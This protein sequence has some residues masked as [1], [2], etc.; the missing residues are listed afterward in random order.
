MALTT[1]IGFLFSVALWVN[2]GEVPEKHR[3]QQR[4]L[5]MTFAKPTRRSFLSGAAALGAGTAVG[6]FPYIVRAA[7]RELFVGGFASPG[8]HEVLFPLIEKKHNFK[9]LYEGTNSLVNLEKM[10]A[11]KDRPTMSVVMMDDPVL[12]LAER[13]NLI[14]PLSSLGLSNFA[15][16]K[17][18][19]RPR[20][21]VWAN[22]CQPMA[23]M[24]Y[25]TQ[26]LPEGLASYADAFDPKF[27]DRIILLSMRITQAVVPLIAAASLATG[28]PLSECLQEADA[29]FEKLK[30]LKSNILQVSTNT[31]QAQQMLE[32]GECDLFLSPDS[33]SVLYRK[34]EGAP[35][36][37]ALPKEGVVAMPAGLAMV[38]DGPNQELAQ[39]FIDEI[40]N[41]ETQAVIAKTF[42]SKPTNAKTVLPEG[43]SFPE[44][45]VL[46]WEYFSDNRVAW[47]DRF[48]REI[49][50][51]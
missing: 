17:A 50:A 1:V 29:G 42:F 18:E 16:V 28:K 5:K 20:D 6:G 12:V 46:D 39:L 19:A 35:C 34:S 38:K 8:L 36:D 15:D 9:I 43:L 47:I 31:P 21:G 22:W 7:E 41:P 2:G 49:A 48:E 14:T 40:L 11:N 10:R 37:L 25:N 4:C 26:A 44:M 30:E 3:I 24:A 23:S 33:R 51:K 27:A 32:T 13:E 45:T